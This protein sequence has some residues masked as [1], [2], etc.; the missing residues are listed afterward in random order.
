[1]LPSNEVRHLFHFLVLVWQEEL[2][3]FQGL[4]RLVSILD[5]AVKASH[6][7]LKDFLIVR[8]DKLFVVLNLLCHTL[9]HS[10]QVI[11]IGHV[12]DAH[13]S[14]QLS[15]LGVCLAQMTLEVSCNKCR[16]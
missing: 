12:L 13:L 6:T 10:R 15:E 1:M 11:K 7:T 9:S 3:G 8:H 14:I 5:T 2:Q 4:V 16:L